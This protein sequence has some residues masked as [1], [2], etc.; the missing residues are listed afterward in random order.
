MLMVCEKGE[1]K[2]AQK[3]GYQVFWHLRE[4]VNL[5]TRMRSWYFELGWD[6]VNVCRSF[7]DRENFFGTCIF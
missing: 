3:Q 4:L 2:V 5:L 6:E 1:S 7:Q